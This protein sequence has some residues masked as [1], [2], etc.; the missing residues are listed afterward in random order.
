MQAGR[1]SD[2]SAEPEP[3][4]EAPIGTPKSFSQLKV[5]RLF[6]VSAWRELA[7]HHAAWEGN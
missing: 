1:F 3:E 7:C 2:G 5:D 4:P 6:L